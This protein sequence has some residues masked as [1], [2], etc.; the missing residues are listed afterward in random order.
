MKDLTTFYRCA[1]L[2]YT[3]KKRGNLDIIL[4]IPFVVFGSVRPVYLKW[5]RS[6]N[7]QQ[8][9]F[10]LPE[11]ICGSLQL[12]LMAP[13]LPPWCNKSLDSAANC[14]LSSPPQSFIVNIAAS[15]LARSHHHS[16]CVNSV[17]TDQ[18]NQPNVQK[19][20]VTLISV[21][22]YTDDI[23]SPEFRFSFSLP[24]EVFQKIWLLNILTSM[25]IVWSS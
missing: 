9:G 17:S 8:T 3:C 10:I 12:L 7:P 14:F 16:P 24:K 18:P 4:A 21:V 25:I 15:S 22:S 23:F 6:F 1:L 20:S 19:D 13:V 2:K 5:W 11:N